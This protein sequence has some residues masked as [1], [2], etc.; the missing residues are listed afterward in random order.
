MRMRN[1]KGV[2]TLW[3]ESIGRQVSECNGDACVL[4]KGEFV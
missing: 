1:E 4:K 3:G 2:I